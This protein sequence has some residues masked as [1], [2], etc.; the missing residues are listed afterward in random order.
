M[1]MIVFRLSDYYYAAST[2]QIEEITTALSPTTVPK[3]P[4]WVEGLVNLRGDVLTLVSMYNLLKID[5]KNTDDCYN[6]T[7]V[8][9]LS[10]N[11]IALMVDEI[12]G[13]TDV[14]E[15]DFQPT[16]EDEAASVH[17]LITVYD[18]IV[19]VLDLNN[20]FEEKED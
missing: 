15:D 17:S 13:V 16:T 12:I 1:Q 20:L 18:Q 19:N 10:E 6:N 3:S 7:I 11:S 5:D 2:E 4:A 8:A 14:A 9:K